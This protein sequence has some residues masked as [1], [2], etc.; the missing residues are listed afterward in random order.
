M[1]ES[2]VFSRFGICSMS[3]PD[4][5]RLVGRRALNAISARLVN[6][7][8]TMLQGFIPLAMLIALDVACNTLCE[9]CSYFLRAHR[10]ESVV[11][12]IAAASHVRECERSI[13]IYD[14]RA[15]PPYL[16]ESNGKFFSFLSVSQNFRAT[17]KFSVKF[18]VPYKQLTQ[19]KSS[20][21]FIEFSRLLA[22]AI[23]E[24]ENC[25]AK[26]RR[27]NALQCIPIPSAQH[28]FCRERRRE[29]GI[30]YR[31]GLRHREES[32]KKIPPLFH[33]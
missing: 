31:G 33:M 16:S 22:R 25:H 20:T 17:N 12:E 9:I 8:I 26:N 24:R 30:S 3:S 1:S 27:K 11:S 7:V 13:Q 14:S 18:A 32:A 10:E 28:C 6:R 19:R 4:L 23:F 15:R 2:R 21:N 5:R 29:K